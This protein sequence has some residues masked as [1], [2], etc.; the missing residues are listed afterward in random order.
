MALSRDIEVLRRTD[1]FSGFTGDQLLLVAFTARQIR[2]EPGELLL[3]ENDISE[4]A[5]VVAEG[6]LSLEAGGQSCGIAGP[7]SVLA[8]VALVSPI[9]HRLT[10]TADLR[11]EIF[12]ISREAFIK[13]VGEYPDIGEA[14]DR[15]L[16][17]GFAEMVSALD[18]VRTRLSDF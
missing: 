2:L 7:G 1:L 5:Y 10:A 9:A 11:S 16:R 17:Q 18:S 13:L 6:K 14:M 15:R 4:G 8:E 12:F 3:R